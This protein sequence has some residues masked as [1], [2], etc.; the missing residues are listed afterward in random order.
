LAVSRRA[1]PSIVFRA[2]M[3]HG[4]S[5]HCRRYSPFEWE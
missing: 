3:L 2:A 5:T 1:V 4:I